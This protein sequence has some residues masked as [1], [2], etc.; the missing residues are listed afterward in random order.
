MDSTD[1]VAWAKKLFPAMH[2]SIRNAQ[3]KLHTGHRD[4][5]ASFFSTAVAPPTTTT[6]PTATTAPTTNTALRF[7]MQEASSQRFQATFTGS[8][9]GA[10]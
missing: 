3:P 6:T 1:L 10:S 2:Q 9:L 5:H 8:F 4:I 7:S